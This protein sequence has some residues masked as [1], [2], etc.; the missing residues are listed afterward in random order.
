MI[1]K[2]ERE[3]L[4]KHA[5][6]KFEKVA[7]LQRL[8]LICDDGDFVPTVHYP[9]ITEYPDQGPEYLD[10]YVW[11]EDNK[12]DIYVHIPFCIQQCTY[13][14]YPNKVGPC[15]DEKEKYIGYLIREMDIFLNKFGKENL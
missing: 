7:E 5:E 13:C 3:L 4:Y 11:P 6:E 9:P 2:D 15:D 1:S 14:H 12:M 8:G 10:D